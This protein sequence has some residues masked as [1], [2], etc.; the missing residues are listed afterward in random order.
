MSVRVCFFLNI[1]VHSDPS[2]VKNT[3]RLKYKEPF[4]K[5][6]SVKERTP[7]SKHFYTFIL[8]C[9]Y[10]IIIYIIILLLCN[11]QYCY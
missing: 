8:I 2:W 9:L 6:G 11:L 1:D 3:Y 5:G 7:V 10:Y 4:Y